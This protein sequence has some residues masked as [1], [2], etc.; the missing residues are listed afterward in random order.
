[1]ELAP[2]AVLYAHP[3][4]PYTQALLAAVP[5]PDPALAA[6]RRTLLEGDPP[7]PLQPPTGCAFHPRCAFAVERCRT[8]TPMLRPM[9]S[10]AV[11]CHRAEEIAMPQAALPQA[12]SMAVEQRLAVLEAAR[13]EKIST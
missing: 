11:A 13:K 12:R 4:H 2:K 10:A 6:T 7:S 3:R 5:R 8:E 9:D 1:V